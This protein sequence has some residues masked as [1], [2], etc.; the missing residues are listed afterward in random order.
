[1]SVFLRMPREFLCGSYYGSSDV[2]GDAHEALL[3]AAQCFLP[4]SR[5][6]PDGSVVRRRRGRPR[7]CSD[8]A[9]GGD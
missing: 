8:S 1:M 6:R 2:E 5:V 4:G 9:T 3:Q 7:R